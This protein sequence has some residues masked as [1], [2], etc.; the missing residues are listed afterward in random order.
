MSYDNMMGELVCETTFCDLRCKQIINVVDGACLGHAV[1]IV[2]DIKC[3]KI[4]GI[5]APGFRRFFFFFRPADDIFIPWRH[6]CKIGE[7]VILVEL[8]PS[9][10]WFPGAGK[11]GRRF[12]NRARSFSAEA[13]RAEGAK[14]GG[15]ERAG[16]GD[17]RGGVRTESVNTDKEEEP[18]T[19]TADEN[20]MRA[21]Y[22]KYYDVYDIPE[23][24]G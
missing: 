9:C 6:V 21:R 15:D 17:R 14:K 2:F 22:A 3:G 24:E 19:D 7:D 1:D 5:I 16:G 20:N 12:D 18:Q 10:G 13:E 11:R 23:K 8:G 4:L